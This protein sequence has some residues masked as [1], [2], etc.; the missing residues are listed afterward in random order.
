[1]SEIFY[2]GDSENVVL[3]SCYL[4]GHEGAVSFHKDQEAQEDEED[5][6]IFQSST[7]L[8][9]FI[10]RLEALAAGAGFARVDGNRVSI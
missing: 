4:N 10:D 5:F 2:V 8:F 7:E 9:G 1:M 3:E 6:V